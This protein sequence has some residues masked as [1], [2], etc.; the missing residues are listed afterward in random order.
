MAMMRLTSG[1]SLNSQ[2][3]DL[4]IGA[5]TFIHEEFPQHIHILDGDCV[6]IGYGRENIE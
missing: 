4:V 3:T 6:T 2:E 1:I 5:F